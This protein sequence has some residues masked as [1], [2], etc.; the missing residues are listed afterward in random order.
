MKKSVLVLLLL[1]LYV[2]TFGFQ[3]TLK[4]AKDTVVVGDEISCKIS[5]DS[6][7]PFVILDS[8]A[9][10][11]HKYWYDQDRQEI[12]AELSKR[13]VKEG[14]NVVDSIRVQVADSMYY[15][16]S[17]NIYTVGRQKFADTLKCEYPQKV[18]IGKKFTITF[19]SNNRFES[20][21]DSRTKARCDSSLEYTVLSVNTSFKSNS[22]IINGKVNA[23]SQGIKK[24][25]FIAKEPGVLKIED[26]SFLFLSRKYFFRPISIIVEK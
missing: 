9:F 24:I 23:V 17:C 8:T 13:M 16:N 6:L 1:G 2:N 12:F 11:S 4:C 19:T 3:L 18:E 25:Q 26:E 14:K 5:I 10:C 7:V 21:F 20:L 15:T 22:L